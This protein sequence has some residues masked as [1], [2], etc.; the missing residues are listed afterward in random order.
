[1]KTAELIDNLATGMRPA[2]PRVPR[3]LLAMAVGGGVALALLWSTFGFRE[4]LGQAV[5]SASFWMKSTFAL[6]TAVVAFGLCARVARPESGPGLWLAALVLPPL[7]AAGMAGIEMVSATPADRSML[8]LGHSVAK[9][10]VCIA[11]LAVP[12]LFAVLWAFRRFAPTRL[13]LAGFSGGLLAGAI[14]AAVYSMHCEE[15]SLLFVATWYGFGM[16]LPAVLGLLL[17]PRMLRW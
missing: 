2:L 14:A 4:D 6:A 10:L 13:R 15:T 3:L 8:L 12:L 1:M 17:G 7:F 9:C 11:V 16:T 5:L